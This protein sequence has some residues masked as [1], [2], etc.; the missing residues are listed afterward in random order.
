MPADYRDVQ[1]MFNYVV[2]QLKAEVIL[3]QAMLIS[4]IGLNCGSE[5]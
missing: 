4:N 2:V 1:F 5:K 3:G